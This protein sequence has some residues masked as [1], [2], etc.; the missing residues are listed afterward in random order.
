MQASTDGF[1]ATALERQYA[2]L[3]EC[4]DEFLQEVVTLPISS[5]DDRV[6]GLRAWREALLDGHMPAS[7]VWPLPEISTPARLALESL[8][9]L[10]FLKDQ[11]ELVDAFLHDIL[12]SFARRLTVFQGEVEA[13]LRRLEQLERAR[14]TEE[15]HSKHRQAHV[16]LS[17]DTIVRLRDQARRDVQQRPSDVDSEILAMWSERTRAWSAISDVFDDL[18]LFMGRGWDL[19]TGVLKHVGWMDVVRLRELIERLPQLREVVQSL[20]RLHSSEAAETVADMVFMPMRRLEEER[21]EVQTTRVPADIRGIERGGEIARMLPVE[22]AN[23]G[24]P[25]LRYLW[26]ARRAERALVTYRVEGIEIE[27]HLIETESKHAVDQ[28][29]PRPKRGA[30]IAVVDTSGSMHGL[31]ER[32]AKALVLEALRTAHAE[33]RQCFVYAYG[34]PK[35]IIEHEL[36]VSPEGLGQLLAFLGMTFGGGSDEIGVMARV[37]KR[38]EDEAW[39]KADIVLVS[40]GEW[41]PPTTLVPRIVAARSAGTRFHGVQIGNRGRTGLHTICD[42]VH[43]F[44][45]WLDL[46]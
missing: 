8:G 31:P 18:G 15:A 45:D 40:D 3:D 32:V 28:R 10:R 39:T 14:I 6:R 12:T 26:H 4:P 35:Q 24:H 34:G 38:L 17:D 42:P 9:V 2:F 21:R 16:R 5:L 25:K 41:P 46:N 1:D 27:R 7:D 23:L 13:Q 29:R 22:A 43:V 20:G 30:I 33:K 44:R 11:P 36:A 19:S 37:L